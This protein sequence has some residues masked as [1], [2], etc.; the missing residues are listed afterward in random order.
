[1]INHYIRKTVMKY[2][3]FEYFY[4]NILLYTYILLLIVYSSIV[5]RQV[6]FKH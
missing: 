6:N 5:I 2:T 1:M 3:I 4:K